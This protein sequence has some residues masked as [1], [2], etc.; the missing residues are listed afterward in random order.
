MARFGMVRGGAAI[1]IT[2]LREAVDGVVLKRAVDAWVTAPPGEQA[3]RFAGAELAR[4]L[5]ESAYSY[6]SFLIALMLLVERWPVLR[7]KKPR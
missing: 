4:W 3:S 6:Q 5:E 7:S 2:A 1:A